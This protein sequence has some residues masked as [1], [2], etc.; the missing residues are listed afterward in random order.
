MPLSNQRR[1]VFLAVAC[2]AATTTAPAVSTRNPL[3][4]VDAGRCQDHRGGAVDGP[5]WAAARPGDWAAYR[6]FD[7]DSGVAAFRATVTATAAGTLTVRLDRP[8]GPLMGTAAVPPTGGNALDVTC[9]VDHGQA[10]VRD[11][12]LGFAAADPAAT[13]AVRSFV[14]LKST[15]PVKDPPPD[16]SARVDRPDDGEPQATAAFGMP[17]AGFTDDLADLARWSGHG[18]TPGPGGAT[19][20]GEASALTPH[21]YVNKTDTG[22]DWRTLAQAALTA[23]VT[24]VDAA[25]RPGVGFASA[26]GR[27]WVSVTLSPADDALLAT[28][29]LADGSDVVVRRHPKL[30]HDPAQP[31]TAQPFHIT[32]GQTYRLRLAWSPYAD[33]LVVFLSDAANRPLTSFRTVV[34]LPVARRPMLVNAGGASR[35][36][37]VVFDPRLD[38][39]VPRWQWLKRPVLSGDVCN[40]AVWRWTDGQYYMVWRQFGGD[41]FHGIATSPDAVH[42]TT[43][44]RRQMRSRGDMNVL[45]DPFGDGRVWVTPGG[46]KLPWWSSDGR[47]GFTHWDRTGKTVG[48]IHGNSRIQEVVDTARFKQLA[49]VEL[50]GTRYRFVA[51]T[52]NW[53]DRPQPHTVVMLSNTLTDWTVADEKPVVPPRDDFWGEKGTAV[54]SAIPLPDGNILLAAC[55]CT[56]EGYTG[57]PEPTNVSVVVDGRRPWRVLRL[58]TLPDAPVSRENVWYQGPNFGTAL[59]YDAASDTLFY[60]GGF[61]DNTIGM[62]RATGFAHGQPMR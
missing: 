39:W 46:N 10:G 30:A 40:P 49:P 20:A 52:E 19:A 14:F 45:V 17:E 37:H 61:H 9:P 60:Y 7:F 22:G 51:F 41:T 48:D 11:V 56:N 21:A 12:Y 57:A 23:D 53:T 18:L 34:D 35:F 27:E 38:D 1:V 3:A 59:T 2:L 26:D 55:A 33:A 36:A 8:D 47:D 13:V 24:P 62:M 4:P 58:A 15:V 28:R 43:T 44:D 31:P 5:A 29:H 6:A 25:A 50:N 16:L 42:W 32:A 54:G